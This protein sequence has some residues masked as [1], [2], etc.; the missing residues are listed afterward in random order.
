MLYKSTR[1]ELVL[2]AIEMF[3]MLEKKVLKPHIFK[4]YPLEQAGQAQADI[5][6]R[7]TTGSVVL[8]V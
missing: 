3:A 1:H 6:A 5:E 8:T 2:S 4:S 7:L